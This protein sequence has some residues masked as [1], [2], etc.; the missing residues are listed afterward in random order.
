[1]S[2]AVVTASVAKAGVTSAAIMT[3]ADLLAQLLQR[4]GG[5]FDLGRVFRFAIVGLTCHGPYFMLGFGWVDRIFGSPLGLGGKVLWGVLAKKVRSGAW[6]CSCVKAE[7]NTCPNAA[8]VGPQVLTTQLVLNPPYMVILF[9]WMGWLEGR[10]N[11]AAIVANVRAKWPAAFWMGNAF[12]PVANTLNF[13]FVGPDYRVAYVAACGA[14]WN[15]YIS[16]M[17]KRKDSEVKK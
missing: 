6:L 16:W 13:R 11:L 9:A 4:T 1:M 7:Q 10:R 12:W 3:V 17:N 2:G 14:V 15:T 5:S 8:P